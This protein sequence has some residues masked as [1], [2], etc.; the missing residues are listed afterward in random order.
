MI[1]EIPKGPPVEGEEPF[2][3][4]CKTVRSERTAGQ[5]KAEEKQNFGGG[6]WSKEMLIT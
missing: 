1:S 2:S 3:C 5:M 4:R 6:D